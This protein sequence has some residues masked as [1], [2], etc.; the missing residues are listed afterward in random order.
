MHGKIIKLPDEK[1][2]GIAIV[3]GEK[4]TIAVDISIPEVLS[5][6]LGVAQ[7]EQLMGFKVTPETLFLR[8][9]NVIGGVEFL[10]SVCEQ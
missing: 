7:L 2:T 9:N 3:E 6:N 1:E 8:K 10:L 5:L 4:H